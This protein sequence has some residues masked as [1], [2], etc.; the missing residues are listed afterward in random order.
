MMSFVPS[1]V[2]RQ[3]KLPVEIQWKMNVIS[4]SKCDHHEAYIPLHCTEREK[5]YFTLQKLI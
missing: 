2:I 1:F 5:S 4:V 3:V